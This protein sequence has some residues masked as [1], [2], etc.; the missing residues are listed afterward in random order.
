MQ[1]TN[2]IYIQ[3]F[4]LYND[5]ASANNRKKY[6]NIICVIKIRINLRALLTTINP[7]MN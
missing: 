1:S 5:T 4:V 6:K 3:Y 2:T 7:V